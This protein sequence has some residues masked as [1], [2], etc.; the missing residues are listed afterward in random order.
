MCR[1]LSAWVRV[2][3]HG[4][5]TDRQVRENEEARPVPRLFFNTSFR[6]ILIVA[7]PWLLGADWL[8][9]RGSDNRG[10]AEGPAAVAFD[11]ASGQGVAWKVPLPGRGPSSPIAVAG[12]V[13]VTASSGP[14]Q[15]ELHVLCFDAATG[16]QLWQRRMWAT[17]ST[18]LNSFGAAAAPTPASDGQ[19]VFAFYSSND[20]ACFDLDGKL[21]WYRGLSFES[22]TTRN[23]VGMASSPLVVD[24]MVIVQCDCQ[25]ESFVM[26]LDAAS[27]ATRWRIERERTALWTSPTLLT[28]AKGEK[29]ALVQGRSKLTALRPAT[30]ATA[31]EYE[32]PCHTIASAATDDGIVYLPAIGLHAI[33]SDDASDAAKR[34]WYEDRMRSDNCSPLAAGG[35]VFVIKSPGILVAADAANGKQLWQLRLTGPFWA[36]PV[37]VGDR[38]V[39]VNHA[40]LVQIVKTEPQGEL[41]A[42]AQIDEGILATPAAADG[43]LYFRSDRQLWR[44]GE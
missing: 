39:C 42:T 40:G 32:A 1:R 37:L 7:V 3:A 21:L 27:G 17:G 30:G 41:V 10:V 11:P 29:F 8:Q 33:A 35:K 36:S 2:R 26:G 20:L 19:R 13:I 43:A 12:R 31:W 34:L 6:A 14:R 38:L 18:I 16:K 9:F 5:E 4:R 22:P 28:T 15:N 24:G 25:G 23:D 44:V